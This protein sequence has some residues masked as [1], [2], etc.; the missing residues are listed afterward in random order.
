MSMTH[1]LTDISNEKTFLQDPTMS[2]ATDSI[3]QSHTE[4]LPVAKGLKYNQVPIYIR[5]DSRG[6]NKCGGPPGKVYHCNRISKPM[7]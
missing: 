1:S 6:K 5:G 3:M 2:L 7:L 4:A